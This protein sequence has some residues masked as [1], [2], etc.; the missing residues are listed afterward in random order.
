MTLM[1]TSENIS[2]KNRLLG[3]DCADC[4]HAHL[5]EDYWNV[6]DEG[7]KICEKF[8]IKLNLFFKNMQNEKI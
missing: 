6:V 7:D 4:K 3:Y 2:A 5:C 1:N 8:S